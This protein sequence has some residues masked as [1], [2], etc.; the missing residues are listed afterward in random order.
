MNG[1]QDKSIIVTGGAD[2][3][4]AAAAKLLAEHGARVTIA[5]LNDEL[6]TALAASILDRGGEAQ[7]IHTDIAKVDDVKAMVALAVQT[8]GRLDGAF[9]NAGVPNIG[10]LLHEVTVE[11]WN[12]CMAVNLTGTFYC[13]KYEIEAMLETGGGAIVNTSSTAGLVTVPVTAEYT[14]SKH[15]VSGLTKAA[16]SDYGHHNIRVNAIAPA[17]VRTAMY[18]RFAQTNPQFEEQVAQLHPIGR[19][20]EPV[21]QASAALWLLSDAAS[22][23]TGVILPVD[24]GYTAV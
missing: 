17:A 19:S 18:A 15:G 23:V 3:I 10:R 9:N 20:S 6:G 4:G 5:D 2:G 8:F 21:E 11:E 24:G 1:I 22:F 14:A 13:M 16:A 12:R 7:F